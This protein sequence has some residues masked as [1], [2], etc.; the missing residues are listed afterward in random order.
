MREAPVQV[1]FVLG[2]EF[3]K[4]ELYG[5]TLLKLELE[6]RG[7]TV[8]LVN[9]CIDADG[10]HKR[11]TLAPKVVVY[12][13]IYT[14]R[15]VVKA[16]QFVGQVSHIVNLQSEQIFSSLTKQH[17]FAEGYAK[18]ARHVCWGALSKD[19]FL[20]EE[21]AEDHV[22]V[23]GNIHLDINHPRFAHIFPRRDKFAQKF[24]LE[25]KKT[26]AMFLSNFK[27]AVLYPEQVFPQ[28]SEDQRTLAEIEKKTYRFVLDALRRFLESHDDMEII[29]RPH[30]DEGRMD[31]DALRKMEET[32]AHFHVIP[33]RSIQEWIRVCDRFLTYI[34]T[35][36]TDVI[37]AG[38]P[39][40][41]LR[42]VSLPEA[43]DNDVFLLNERPVKTYEELEAFLTGKE[44]FEIAPK[45]SLVRVIENLDA[46]FPAYSRLADWL[47]EI[48]KEPSESFA[49][50][51]YRQEASLKHRL[52]RNVTF[53]RGGT[54]FKW[55]QKYVLRPLYRRT[56]TRDMSRLDFIPRA[57]H[58]RT[59]SEQ[60]ENLLREKQYEERLRPFFS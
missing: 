49:G 39:A 29:Y 30:P 1:D 10:D 59:F 13:W 12:P 23:C 60:R 36:V 32:Y 40:A 58:L 20:A 52:R 28:V 9:R 24:R 2:Y 18:R 43:M 22:R 4:R 27:Q 54:T 56:E 19:R 41:L 42:P 44:P 8:E 37:Y 34:S 55:L 47:E 53:M 50:C 11:L 7:Y 17:K 46:S 14:D 5:L 16:T 3:W 31:Y 45:Q 38:K 33:D 51:T 48:I 35:G 26:W 21:V 6:R 15:D 57:F 25:E